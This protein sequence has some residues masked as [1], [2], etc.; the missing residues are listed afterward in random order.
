MEGLYGDH[1]LSFF[2][3]VVLFIYTRT[4]LSC[5]SRSC[6][7]FYFPLP[8]SPLHEISFFLSYLWPE[9]AMQ[10]SLCSPVI[11]CYCIHCL[12]WCFSVFF[13]PFISSTSILARADILRAPI[14]LMYS[15]HSVRQFESWW[16]IEDR[17]ASVRQS[18]LEHLS[19]IRPMIVLVLVLVLVKYHC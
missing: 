13:V 18:G 9:H 4:S 7:C 11:M 10:I 5:F 17:S 12:S 8:R 15:P 6:M 19:G 14:T 2:P 3:F 1:V 16:L